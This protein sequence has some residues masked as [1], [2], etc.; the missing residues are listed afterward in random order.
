MKK[1]NVLLLAMRPLQFADEADST[2]ARATGGTA[3]AG[4]DSTTKQIDGG[5]LPYGERAKSIFKSIGTWTPGQLRNAVE[6]GEAKA[7]R[8]PEGNT[9]MH[10]AIKKDNAP[11]A[12]ML[13]RDYGF[14]DLAET[15]N[16]AGQTCV[17][18]AKEHGYDFAGIFGDV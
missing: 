11:V 13:V 2:T 10:E 5:I 14:R 9:L 15:P 18:L 1:I 6:V 3:R 12:E 16:A 17:V 4:G 8:D 7:L